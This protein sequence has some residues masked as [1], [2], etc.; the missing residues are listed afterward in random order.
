MSGARPAI[1]GPSNQRAAAGSATAAAGS[2]ARGRSF[3]KDGFGWAIVVLVLLAAHAAALAVLLRD[4]RSEEQHATMQRLAKSLARAVEARIRDD[5]GLLETLA[6]SNEL[7]AQDLTNFEHEARRVLAHHPHWRS[8]VLSD[9]ERA[10]VSLRPP[11]G[12][13]P[14][15]VPL[16]DPGSP[17]IGAPSERRAMIGNLR[18]GLVALRVPAARGT[19]RNLTLSVA[20][21]PSAFAP[22]IAPDRLPAG[23][24]AM[25]LDSRLV[26]V[27]RGQSERMVGQSATADVRRIARDAPGQIEP[28][29]TVDG[30]AALALVAPIGSTGWYLGLSVPEPHGD[31]FRDRVLWWPMAGAAMALLAAAALLA[32]AVLRRRRAAEAEAMRQA[33]ERHRNLMAERRRAE[34]VATISHQVRTPLAGIMA[35]AELLAQSDL[36]PQQRSWVEQQRRAGHALLALVGDMLDV[37]RLDE[38][39]ARLRS[40]DFDLLALLQD[41]GALLRPVAEHKGLGL[42][43]QPDPELPRWVRGDEARLRQAVTNLISNAIEAIEQGEVTVSART[44]GPPQHLLVTV[45]G[46]GAGIAPE[47]LAEAFEPFRPNGTAGGSTPVPAVVAPPDHGGGFGLAVTQQLV[48]LMGGS[49]WAENLPDL[50]CCFR[51]SVPLAT[52]LA[53]PALRPCGAGLSVLVAE[54]VAASR[55]LLRAVLERGG[56]RVTLAEDGARALATLHAGRF[57]LALLDLHM[58]GLDGLAVARAVRRQEGK[59][60]QIPLV[61][62]TADPEE[63][64]GEACR[65]AGFD[66]VLRKPAESRRLL[67]LVRS[68]AVARRQGDCG[69]RPTARPSPPVVVGS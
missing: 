20:I 31:P 23:W 29:L 12:L 3:A 52:G 68:L 37:A 66:A 1:A 64:V 59:A 11:P 15:V 35:H 49:I 24:D 19:G 42:R 63:A 43:L 5:L 8:L 9:G 26:T 33:S 58:P 25:I 28:I 21:L 44:S 7:W 41:C 57:D 51:F 32:L 4:L 34:L 2:P 38:G 22:L 50:G 55:M 17:L 54:D 13:W 62:L 56:H 67:E 36:S 61:A 45:A 6:E 46:T 48:A 39:A 30:E 14:T 10:L 40:A 18:D 47:R 53:P 16:E 69:E 27:A 60:G 65:V